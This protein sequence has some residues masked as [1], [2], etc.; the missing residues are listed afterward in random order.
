M[1]LPDGW[2]Q[3]EMVSLLEH[4]PQYGVNC[5]S[6]SYVEGVTSRLIRIT[7]I[8][9]SG[10][11]IDQPRVGVP[12]DETAD[13]LVSQGDLLLARSGAT[14]GK[15]V[16][17]GRLDYPA[18][19]AGYLIRFRIDKEKAD[20]GFI[21]QFLGS[22]R[23]WQWVRKTLRAGAQ[24]NINSEEYCSLV[25]PLPAPG[26]QR[27]LRELLETWDGSGVLCDRLIQATE[28]RK[29]GLMLQLLTGK[30]RF[31]EFVKSGKKVKTRYG[32][33]PDDWSQ[34]HMG[35]IADAAGKK[36]HGR[37][38]LPVL[39]CTKYRGL[40]NSLEYFGKRIFSDDTSTYR[41]VQRG[42]FAYATNHIEEGSIGYQNLHD[43]ALI[44]PMYTVFRT[45]AGVDHEFFFK[46]IKTELYRHIFEV[47]TSGSIARRGAL[48]WDEFALI[49]VFL[50]TEPEQKRIAAV[51]NTCDREIELLQKE[52]DALKEQKRGL[53][54][55]LLTGEIRVKV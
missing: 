25:I 31:E 44:S 23:Y 14:V 51:L 40:V 19:F 12:V 55:K 26:E 7:D 54:Q 4:P 41:I 6:V 3:A 16:L 43:A 18:A 34:V 47:N 13:R 35:D 50:P 24:P 49:K 29:R 9:G 28:Q 32:D 39:S 8:N 15:S 42:D 53:M 21:K 48:R 45:R 36:N 33:F 2:K 11:L 5:A 22:G 46:L 27:A 10:E 38:K 1:R 30:T 20:R 52:L 37:G 17:I